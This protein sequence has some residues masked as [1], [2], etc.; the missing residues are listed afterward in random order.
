MINIGN[1]KILFF[2]YYGE[3]CHLNIDLLK[4]G[5]INI[6]RIQ[7]AFVFFKFNNKDWFVSIKYG[8]NT[9]TE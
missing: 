8:V 9:V 3:V 1:S 2:D 4:L 7:N 6:T 5:I